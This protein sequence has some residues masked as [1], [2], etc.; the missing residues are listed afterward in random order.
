METAIC[1]I[2]IYVVLWFSVSP[3]PFPSPVPLQDFKKFLLE[4]DTILT[5]TLAAKIGP[6]VG[7]RVP[8]KIVGW[9]F[10]SRT[11][12]EPAQMGIYRDL[13][14]KITG[15]HQWRIVFGWF[16]K[17][18][19]CKCG[20][21]TIH[22]WQHHNSEDPIIET[23]VYD[24]PAVVVTSQATRLPEGVTYPTTF[25]HFT[26]SDKEIVATCQTYMYLSIYLYI[27]VYIWPCEPSKLRRIMVTQKAESWEAIGWDA[28]FTSTA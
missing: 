23:W 18:L 11:E 19:L 26:H 21:G 28:Y 17:P 24:Q 9:Y 15:F 2:L 22:H 3:A 5:K 1:S 6:L 4:N 12:V 7:W 27:H 16:K 13:T 10:S 25:A 14:R 20:R 8:Q